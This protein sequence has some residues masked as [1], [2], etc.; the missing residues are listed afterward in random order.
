MFNDTGKQVRRAGPAA[1]VEILGLSS[2]PQVGDALTVAVNEN[3]ARDLIEKRKS[4]QVSLA[5]K[6][7]SLV[8]LMERV[9][10][11]QVKELNVILKTDVQGSIEPI[12]S[13]LEQLTTDEVKVRII[14]SATGNITE[15]DVLL[16]IAS[17]GII[18]GF[19]ASTEPGAKRLA[20]IQ[21]INIRNYDVIYTMVDD[22]SKALKGLLEPSR[23][24]VVDGRAEVRAVFDA[25]KGQKVAGVFVIE[26]KVNRGASVRVLRKGEKVVESIVSSLRRF[27][28]DV[29]EVGAGFECGVGLKD[30][31]D[32]QSGDVME[33]FRVEEVDRG[34]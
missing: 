21:G 8:N 24:E 25:A 4:G 32:F 14:H 31:S 34:G 5:Q 3:Q 13:S 18:I 27:K 16:A 9:S 26:G 7:V 33:F 15:S 20:E 2:V 10:A 12:K 28:E 6:P 30:F 11:G 17:K 22:V 1:P 29:R 23:I 19:N